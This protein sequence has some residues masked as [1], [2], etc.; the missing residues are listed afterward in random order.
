MGKK[1][2]NIKPHFVLPIFLSRVMVPYLLLLIV[3][4]IDALDGEID[5]GPLDSNFYITVTIMTAILAG[6]IL[7]FIKAIFRN[8]V[9]TFTK[10]SIICKRD[11]PFKSE[12]KIPYSTIKSISIKQNWPHKSFGTGSLLLTTYQGDNYSFYSLGKVLEV[13]T[14]ISKMLQKNA[15]LKPL[16]SEKNENSPNTASLSI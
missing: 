8:T 3:F 2:I 11:F 10:E 9:Y 7:P 1:E 13:Q 12:T 4:I 16:S 5:D 6:V 15:T 14:L